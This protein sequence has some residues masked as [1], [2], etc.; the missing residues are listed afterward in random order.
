MG[1]QIELLND[2]EMNHTRGGIR[3][4][5]IVLL[6]VLGIIGHENYC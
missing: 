6:V 2:S 4:W 5:L 3:V 1:T